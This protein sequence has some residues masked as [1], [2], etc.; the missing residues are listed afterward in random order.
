MASRALDVPFD[1]IH[2]SE[3]AS[4]LVAN[5]VITAA[6][7]GSDLYGSAVLVR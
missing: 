4:D 2:I 6:S 7:I 5:S 1:V 3:T